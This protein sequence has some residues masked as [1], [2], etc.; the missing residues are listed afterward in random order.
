MTILTIE[1]AAKFLRVTRRTLYRRLEIPRV[2]IGHQLKF[3][4]EDLEAWVNCQREG[5]VE[6]SSRPLPVG[7]PH[8]DVQKPA[9][10]H[11]NPIFRMSPSRSA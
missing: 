3:V 10:Y 11:R 8:V 7:R 1:E 9:P 2:R 6:V 4:L 5:V